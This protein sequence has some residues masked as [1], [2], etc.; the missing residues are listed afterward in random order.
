M[1][2]FVLGAIVGGVVM[3]RWRPEIETY[4]GR[5]AGA[6]PVG[7]PQG[8]GGTER[9]AS[10]M[11]A[12]AAAVSG[13]GGTLSAIAFLKEQHE[14]AKRG[15][16]GIA[17]GRPEERGRLWAAL[18]PKLKLHEQLEETHVYGPAAQDARVT[19]PLASWPTRH[20]EEVREAERLIETIDRQP[21]GDGEWMRSVEQLRTALERH[22]QEERVRSGPPSPGSG[23]KHAS[24]RSALRYKERIRSRARKRPDCCCSP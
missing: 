20:Q 17:Q 16:Q 8:H 5:L 3:S 2:R 1:L 14:E 23:T 21:A 9:K 15:F 19:D 4:I 10:E 22:I 24:L 11:A 13:Q 6:R 12:G 18:R 7:Q